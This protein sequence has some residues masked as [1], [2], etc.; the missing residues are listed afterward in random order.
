MHDFR[1]F[2]VRVS[3]HLRVWLSAHRAALGWTYQLGGGTVTA[4]LPPS[5]A[6]R[7]IAAHREESRKTRML[8]AWIAAGVLHRPTAP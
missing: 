1:R 6:G 3:V 2:C 7:I 4:P 5:D 8:L